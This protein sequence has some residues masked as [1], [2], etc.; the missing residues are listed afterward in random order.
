MTICVDDMRFFKSIDA[1]KNLE[2]S[3]YPI[4]TGKSTILVRIDLVQDAILVG[5]SNFLMGA[6]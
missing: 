5:T 2:I 1:L 4:Y 6:R 3:A